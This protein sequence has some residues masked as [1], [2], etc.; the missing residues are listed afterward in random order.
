MWVLGIKLRTSEEQTVL[1][2]FEPPFQPPTS[3]LLHTLLPSFPPPSPLP[4]PLSL[5]FLHH[6][7]KPSSPLIPL[8]LSLLPLLYPFSILSIPS[9]LFLLLISIPLSFLSSNYSTIFP[10]SLFLCCSIS[11]SASSPSTS[12]FSLHLLPPLSSLSSSFISSIPPLHLHS[13]PSFIPLSTFFPS[14]IS[15]IPLSPFPPLSL[16]PFHLPLLHHFS[17]PPPLFFLL[18]PLLHLVYPFSFPFS[19]SSYLF[20]P[21]FHCSLLNSHLLF[22]LLPYLLLLSIVFLISLLLLLIPSLPVHCPLPPSF[23]SSTSF[24]SLVLPHTFSFLFLTL[25]S[26]PSFPSMFFCF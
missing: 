24:L 13:S 6:I 23:F 15:S 4:L 20:Y 21:P 22:L 5:H 26:L 2:T 1:L 3:H 19:F 14:L 9:S 17:S 7:H 25:H 8:P 10:F 11:F 16:F 18:L 12:L